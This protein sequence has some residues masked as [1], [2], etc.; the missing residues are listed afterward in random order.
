MKTT[1]GFF[2]CLCYKHLFLLLLTFG[3]V[4]VPASAQ[5]LLSKKAVLTL[6]EG[7]NIIFDADSPF[8]MIEVEMQSMNDSTRVVMITHAEVETLEATV[9]LKRVGE[10]RQVLACPTGFEAVYVADVTHQ[11]QM[12][13]CVSRE[14]RLG[15]D[16][17]LRDVG[18]KTDPG[19]TQLEVPVWISYPEQKL[20]CE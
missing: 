1:Q 16:W 10:A 3:M 17:A 6:H 7:T 20:C 13:Y 14:G 19:V 9:E 2:L 8:F 15:S 11:Y 4:A 5:H 12:G 18:M